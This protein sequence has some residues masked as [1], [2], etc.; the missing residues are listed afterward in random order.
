[1]GDWIAPRLGPFGGWVGSV[2]PRGYAAYARVLHPVESGETAALTPWDRTCATSGA[3]PHALMQW[4][5]VAGSSDG[6]PDAGNLDAR[7][8]RALC[9][10]LITRTPAQECFFALWEGHGWVDCRGSTPPRPSGYPVEILDRPRLELPHRSYLLFS[11][12]LTESPLFVDPHGVGPQ[13]PN[14][15]W[16]AD[17]SWFVATEIDFDSTIV[18]GSV[19]LVAAVL[20]EPG[21]E[22]WPVGPGDSLAHGGDLINQAGGTA[23]A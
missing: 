11:G 8:L 21:L 18:A 15:F 19:E 13:S 4:S 20:A 7:S 6:T 10:L 17:R 12:P 5:A 22:A 3:T 23:P 9:L 2:A 14:L 16:P 1:M